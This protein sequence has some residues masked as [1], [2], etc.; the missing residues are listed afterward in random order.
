MKRKLTVEQL[1]VL[2]NMMTPIEREYLGIEAKLSI[3]SRGAL[4]MDLWPEEKRAIRR[5][6]ER[7]TPENLYWL[8]ITELKERCRSKGLPDSGS[9]E[10]LVRRLIKTRLFRIGELDEIIKYGIEHEG[11][12]PRYR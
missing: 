10:D 8:T 6:Y 12:S 1:G 11:L 2:W 5:A 3:E 4:W 7:E 9:K